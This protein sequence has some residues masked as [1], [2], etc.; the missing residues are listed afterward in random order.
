MSGS[1]VYEIILREISGSKE[2]KELDPRRKELILA[3]LETE[4]RT[5]SILSMT[6]PLFLRN[7][8]KKMEK[9]VKEKLEEKNKPDE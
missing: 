9:I 7:M 1:L 4:L 6:N 5:R 3:Y 2:Y 8:K